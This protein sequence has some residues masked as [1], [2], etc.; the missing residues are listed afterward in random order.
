MIRNFL[1]SFVL[2]GA[3]VAAP[4]AV[5][6]DADMETL[7]AADVVIVGETHD[8]RDHHLVQ[9]QIAQDIA[10]AAVVFEMLSVSQA[11]RV[12]PDLIGDAARLADVLE[13]EEL[14]WPDFAM[15]YPVFEATADAKVYGAM[16]PRTQAKAVFEQGAAD[17][18][19]E[20]AEQYG[21]TTVL[22]GEQQTQRE[23]LQMAAH[24]DALPE[25]MLPGMVE[26]QRLRDAVLAR[27]TVQALEETGG[28]VLVITGNG[29]A[30]KDWGVPAYLAQVRPYA[31]VVSIGQG[32]EGQV[33]EGGFDMVLDAPAPEREDPCAAFQ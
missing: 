22:T 6:T 29:H 23:R 2:T 4:S 11:L 16:I 28:P 33:P 19:G 17:V 5:L 9:A 3:A 27:A 24:C 21:L 13:W 12:K 1:L 26:V 31:T 32:E 7:R 18:F 14:G 25:D 10:P 30:R 20:G 15:Y 8:N